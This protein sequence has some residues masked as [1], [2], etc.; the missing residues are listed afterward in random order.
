MGIW[1][2]LA[3]EIMFFMGI[4][5][6]YIIFRSG[7]PGLFA[8]HAEGLNKWA[9]AFNTVVLISSSLTMALAVDGAAKGDRRR[10]GLYLLI[11]F[12]CAGTFMVVKY[13]EY[14]SKFEHLTI[15]AVEKTGKKQAFVYDGHWH[16]EAK[17]EFVGYRMPM[18]ADNSFDIHVAS[19]ATIRAG[20]GQSKAETFNLGAMTL[21]V[22][23]N[24]G[25]WRNIFYSCYYTL[26]GIHGLHVL[27]GMVPLGILLAQSWRGKLFPPHTE[28]TGLYWHFVDLVWIFLVPLLYLI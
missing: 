21:G 18:P 6:S 17:K 25:P 13:F 28:Y 16:D 22:T 1:L 9:A 26:T 7:S 15:V 20:S 4:L 3:S 10:T 19:E 23:E 8:Q 2:F 11:T 24:Y 14:K 27:G 5:G 12:L